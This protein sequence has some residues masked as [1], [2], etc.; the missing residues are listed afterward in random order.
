MAIVGVIVVCV[1]VA[2]FFLLKRTAGRSSPGKTGSP[3]AGHDLVENTSGG[4]AR[5]ENPRATGIN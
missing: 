5:P 1:L 3:T 4:D 2:V